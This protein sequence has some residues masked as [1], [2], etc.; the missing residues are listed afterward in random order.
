MENQN[1]FYVYKWFNTKTGEVFYIGKGHKDRYKSLC[2]RNQYF[3]NYIKNNPIDVAFIGTNLTKKEAFQL[4]T[5]MTE[6]YKELGQCKYCLAKGET[7]GCSS[8]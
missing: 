6:Y 3:L 4:E 1:D 8:V 7:D 5:Q 2:H